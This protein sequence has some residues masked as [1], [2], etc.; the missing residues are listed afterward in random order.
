MFGVACMRHFSSSSSQLFSFSRQ[1]CRPRTSSSLH[2]S[3]LHSPTF[4][5]LLLVSEQI[6]I[7]IINTRLFMF[8]LGQLTIQRKSSIE[9]PPTPN[10][11]PIT[12][13]MSNVSNDDSWS[14]KQEEEVN[15]NDFMTKLTRLWND[16]TSG[17]A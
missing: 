17:R 5:W 1:C 4:Q 11:S 2:W 6:L 13:T 12:R 15:K 10:N 14:N 7:I 9:T 8:H 16:Q 3:S